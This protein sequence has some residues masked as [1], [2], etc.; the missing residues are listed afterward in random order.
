[1]NLNIIKVVISVVVIVAGW[2][3][4]HYFNSRRD[5][6][7]N[8]RKMVTSYLVDA[9]RKLNTFACVL[10]SGAKAYQSLVEDFNSAIGDIQL[11]GSLEQ[12]KL[13]KSI[14]EYMAQTNKVPGDHL[15]ELLHNLRNALRNELDLG[16]TDLSIAHLRLAYSDKKQM[17]RIEPRQGID[18]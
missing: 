7:A 18:N 2:I 1:M 16:A 4:G 8:R 10:T 17:S 12:I 9:Y 14:A 5:S 6:A 13:V 3:V 11:F 15:T